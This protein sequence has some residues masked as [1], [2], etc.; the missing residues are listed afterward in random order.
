VQLQIHRASRQ[1][2]DNKN[3]MSASRRRWS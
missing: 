3:A 2:D 1:D